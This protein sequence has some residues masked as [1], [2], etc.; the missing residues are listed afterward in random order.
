M[1]SALVAGLVSLAFAAPASAEER[2]CKPEITATGG[3]AIRDSRAKEKAVEAWR[4]QAVANN[5]IFY[6]NEKDANDGKGITVERCA[7][8]LLGLTIC[9]ARGRPCL[10]K[11]ADKPNEIA[12]TKDDSKNCQPE[13]K[14]VQQRLKDKGVSITVDGSPGPGTAKAIRDFKKKNG[15]G[16]DDEITEKLIEA[17]KA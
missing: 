14:W 6:G 9:Q 5:G 7:K 10:V 13:V 16:N 1:R 3:G 15:L 8:S 4:Q 11:Q 17:L 2:S 12:C